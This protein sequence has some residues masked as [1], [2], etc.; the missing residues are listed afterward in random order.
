[1][2]GSD[3]SPNFDW[4][5]KRPPEKFSERPSINPV[6]TPHP[7]GSDP[8]QPPT[9]DPPD[10]LLI[11]DSETTPSTFEAPS[12]PPRSPYEPEPTEHELPAFPA[13]SAETDS[14]ILDE[15][16]T[17][18]ETDQNRTEV[19]RADE[20]P[21]GYEGLSFSQESGSK[22]A[23]SRFEATPDNAGHRNPTSEITPD[24]P[25]TGPSKLFVILASYASAITIAFLALVLKQMWVN[26][27]P[28]HL[29]SLPDILPQKD[30]ELTFVAPNFTLPP[31]HTLTL[32]E[33]QRFGNILVEPLKITTG[34]LEFT[35]YTGDQ[36][37]TRA[38]SDPVWKLHL[39]LTNVSKDQH[40]A[41]LDR[42]LVLRWIQKSGHPQEYSNYYIIPAGTRNPRE[43]MLQLY[44]LPVNSEWDLQGQSLGKVL[45]PGET[46]ET[47]LASSDENVTTLSDNLLWRVQIRKGYSPS[48][49]GVTTVF[50]VAFDKDEIVPD[51]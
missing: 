6:P 4:L 30:N 32:G 13:P 11:P 28:H 36:R 3:S 38:P 22:L 25:P 51:S 12:K 20:L 16:A 39:R 26:E 47:Y 7:E 10:N 9:S 14:A 34:P 43:F 8:P 48:G 46:Y 37:R 1:M 31:G 2:S 40:I 42:R 23:P 33:K 29:E 17:P 15:A 19:L 49:N 21:K 41:P 45:A 5:N 35:H 24:V 27:T 44:R 18:E 50:Q